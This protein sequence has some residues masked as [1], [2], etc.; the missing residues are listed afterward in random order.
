VIYWCYDAEPLRAHSPNCVDHFNDTVVISPHFLFSFSLLQP[1]TM[2]PTKLCWLALLPL[3][4]LAASPK[5]AVAVKKLWAEATSFRTMRRFPVDADDLA[6]PAGVEDVRSNKARLLF[7]E[8]E[9]EMYA[10]TKLSCVEGIRNKPS[11]VASVAI[12]TPM[13]SCSESH[14]QPDQ[15]PMS[16][17]TWMHRLQ[18]TFRDA[19]TEDTL[20]TTAW[21]R[22]IV[23]EAVFGL[24]CGVAFLSIVVAVCSMVELGSKLLGY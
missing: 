18:T 1:T 12:A 19:K 11:M 22:S 6:M 10:A 23:L 8:E 3:L 20:F 21:A 15:T 4:R 2:L 5:Q 9:V 24:T 16:W 14:S 7:E 17:Q 13:L